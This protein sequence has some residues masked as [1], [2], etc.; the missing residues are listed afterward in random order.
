MVHPPL[1][2]T[3][4]KAK[5]VEPLAVLLAMKTKVG[6]EPVLLLHQGMFL[7][8]AGLSVALANVTTKE[9]ARIANI[10]NT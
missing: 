3:L 4:A 9:S 7:W 2:L 6:Q 1:L 5:R 10:L 8:H